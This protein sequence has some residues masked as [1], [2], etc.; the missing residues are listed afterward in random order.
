MA[1]GGGGGC[2]WCVGRCADESYDDG[3][4]RGADAAAEDD[5]GED[6]A[7]AEGAALDI[8]GG[9]T[10]AGEEETAATLALGLGCS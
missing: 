10:C 9:G 2:G 1:A 6:A 3:P 8:D 5:G 4:G 7:P